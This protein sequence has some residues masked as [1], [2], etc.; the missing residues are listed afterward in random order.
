VREVLADPDLVR[1][2]ERKLGHPGDLGHVEQQQDQKV[3]VDENVDV[4][5]AE[6]HDH[7][8]IDEENETEIGRGDGHDEAGPDP[9]NF[10]EPVE[11]VDDA[12]AAEDDDD[13]KLQDLGV[14]GQVAVEVIVVALHLKTMLFFNCLSFSLAQCYSV[15]NCDIGL[16]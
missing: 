8:R 6:T 9:V 5:R 2:A 11:A 7:K 14:A 3:G 16:K 10:S 4:G 12:E 15:S 13:D 1:R